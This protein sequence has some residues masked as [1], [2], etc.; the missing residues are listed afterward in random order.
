MFLSQPILRAAAT[1]FVI[2]TVV[3]RRDAAMPIAS[4]V[5]M[6]PFSRH[7]R[8]MGRGRPG[9]PVSS[10]PSLWSHLHERIVCPK[11]KILF[12]LRTILQPLDNHISDNRLGFQNGV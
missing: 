10:M 2:G 7:Q 11:N 3:W 9:E 1:T 8:V 12:A 6:T 4:V 5:G